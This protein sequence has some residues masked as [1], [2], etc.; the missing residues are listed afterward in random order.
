MF[1]RSQDKTELRLFNGVKVGR[2]GNIYFIYPIE[3]SS[4]HSI[5]DY[6]SLERCQEILDEIQLGIER[7]MSVF[8]MPEA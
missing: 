3:G 1:I 6:T 7:D 5:G 4:F 2:S 8:E